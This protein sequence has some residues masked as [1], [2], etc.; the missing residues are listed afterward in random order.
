MKQLKWLLSGQILFLSLLVLVASLQDLHAVKA[1]SCSPADDLYL[2]ASPLHG[3]RLVRGADR[4][5]A[6]DR[7]ANMDAW[8]NPEVNSI[9][10]EPMHAH[11]V[12]FIS[13]KYAIETIR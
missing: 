10:R 13:E 11:F 2:T 7:D 12:P 3:Y 8:R 9:N 5:S 1:R 4:T 6:N